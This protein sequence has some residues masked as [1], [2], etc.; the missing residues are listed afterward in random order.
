MTKNGHITSGPADARI[1]VILAHGAG[2]PMDSPFMD[3]YAD[4]IVAARMRC[5]RF[6]F[7][8]MM[9]RRTKG[10]KRP[11]NTMP[12]LL[13][14]WRSA[15]DQVLGDNSGTSL[16]I[17]GKSMGG[18]VA[19]MMVSGASSPIAQVLGLV[20]LGYPF[21]P[22]GKPEK[23]RVDHLITMKLKTLIIQ[24]TRDT[25][26]SVDDVSG[27]ALSDAT[28]IHWL[29]DG[30]HSFKPRKASGRTESQNWRDGAQALIAFAN[31]CHAGKE[32]N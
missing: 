23:L 30:D 15:I 22:A 27:Y 26:G 25:L 16:I 8:Y 28:K 17:G 31:D 12:I 20:C 9:E 32:S 6:E 7:P 4:A 5:V 11:P 10:T 14:S 29:E 19:S 2:A 24:G 21:H 1:T 3:F 18:R 13:E